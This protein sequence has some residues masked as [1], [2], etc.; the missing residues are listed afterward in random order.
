MKSC[1]FPEEFASFSPGNTLNPHFLAV[2]FSCEAFFTCQNRLFLGANTLGEMERHE[3]FFRLIQ[4]SS[5]VAHTGHSCILS[6]DTL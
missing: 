2:K 5:E 1:V 3:G 4:T 6:S